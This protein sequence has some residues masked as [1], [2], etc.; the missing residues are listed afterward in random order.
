M[1]GRSE[2]KRGKKGDGRD[3][4]EGSGDAVCMWLNHSLLSRRSSVWG[5]RKTNNQSR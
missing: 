2:E 5:R 4:E 1:G 3:E